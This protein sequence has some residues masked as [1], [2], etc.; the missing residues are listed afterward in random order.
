MSWHTPNTK[1]RNKRRG[2]LLDVDKALLNLDDV[3]QR[4]YEPQRIVAQRGQAPNRRLLV[5]WRGYPP[6][7]ATW[8]SEA[9]MQGKRVLTEWDS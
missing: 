8:E 5:R 3:A 9:S 4:E 6:S 1:T 2:A 7:A